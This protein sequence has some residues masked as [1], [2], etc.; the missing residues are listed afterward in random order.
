[1]RCV[2]KYNIATC[3]L[4]LASIIFLIIGHPPIMGS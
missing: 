4:K 1:M 3:N 2:N